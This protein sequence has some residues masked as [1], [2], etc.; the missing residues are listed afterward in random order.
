MNHIL[1]LGLHRNARSCRGCDGALRKVRRPGSTLRPVVA[2]VDAT[3]G[4]RAR[5]GMERR[6]SLEGSPPMR[7]GIVLRRRHAGSILLLSLAVAAVVVM[8]QDAAVAAVTGP[9]PAV[10]FPAPDPT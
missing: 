7:H 6:G 5:N 4:R 9:P 1:A 2:D 8:P 3:G 10:P